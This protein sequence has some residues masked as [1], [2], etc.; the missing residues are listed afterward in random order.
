MMNYI[1]ASAVCYLATL[2][3]CNTVMVTQT[4]RKIT[5]LSK[6]G[7]KHLELSF[8][9]KEFVKLLLIVKWLELKVKLFVKILAQFPIEQS[10]GVRLYCNKD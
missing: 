3:Q 8:F 4:K 2:E 7:N 1:L 9:F 6:S 10:Q 5:T